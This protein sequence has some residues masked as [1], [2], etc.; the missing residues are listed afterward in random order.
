MDEEEIRNGIQGP[1]RRNF[2]WDA[3]FRMYNANNPRNQLRRG[4]PACIDIVRNWFNQR[5]N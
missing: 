3:A 5:A 2:Y 1:Y 4:C